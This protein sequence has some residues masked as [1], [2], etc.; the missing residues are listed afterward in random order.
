MNFK[1]S[2]SYRWGLASLLVLGLVFGSRQHAFEGSELLQ[3]RDGQLALYNT[4]N[5]EYINIRY[6]DVHG[7]WSPDAAQSFN[8]FLRCH[9]DGGLMPMHPHLLEVIDRIQD[10]FGP[11]RVVHV[12]SAYRSPKYNG[13]LRSVGR[14][15]ALH[16]YHMKGQAMDIR[17][18]GISTRALFEYVKSLGVGGAGCYHG[19]NFVHVDVGPVRVWGS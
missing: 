9:A 16:S 17:I 14:G 6:C 15:V 2:Q 12:I 13:Y 8:H 1:T 10:H 18:P 3:H 11:D 4:H 7:I 5:G 19:P